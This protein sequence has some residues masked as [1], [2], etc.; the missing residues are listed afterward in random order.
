MKSFVHARESY[1]VINNSVQ[2]IAGISQN[3]AIKFVI[4]KRL[5]KLYEL[6][7]VY[8]DLTTIYYIWSIYTRRKHEGRT[9]IIG[10]IGGRLIRSQN[11]HEE[12]PR[13]GVLSGTCRG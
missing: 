2:N 9:M 5:A 11:G 8:E 13:V 7:S 4:G 1:T 10:S 6:G 3:L 12:L